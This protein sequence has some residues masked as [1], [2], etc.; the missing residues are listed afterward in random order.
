MN[1]QISR[2]EKI[3]ISVELILDL[4]DWSI[5]TDLGIGTVQI[6]F[7]RYDWPVD[8]AIGNGKGI[9]GRSFPYMTIASVR[10]ST[11]L[12]YQYAGTRSSVICCTSF[13]TGLHR[14]PK[15]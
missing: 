5:E 11:A 3:H 14:T 15:P 4:F 1:S 13:R 10:D 2:L 6:T 8:I 12:V 9:S 7:L